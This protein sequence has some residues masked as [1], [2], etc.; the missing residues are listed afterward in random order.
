MFSPT[1]FVWS[2]TIAISSGGFSQSDEAAEKREEQEF[3]HDILWSLAIVSNWISDD[4]L[5]LNAKKCECLL[6]RRPK[7]QRNQT[8]EEDISFSINGT[9]IKPNISR[10]LL[11]VHI[12]DNLNFS[13]HVTSLLCKQA[14]K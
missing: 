11:G 8:N 7:A 4:G 9:V 1:L 5:I 3:Y 14:N 10:K 6:F 2:I 13:K 12:D